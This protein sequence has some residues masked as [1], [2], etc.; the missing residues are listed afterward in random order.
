MVYLKFY[1]DSSISTRI[2]ALEAYN[3]PLWRTDDT[4]DNDLNMEEGIT[5][6]LWHY[7]RTNLTI[8]RLTDN[9]IKTFDNVTFVK[10]SALMIRIIICLWQ[11]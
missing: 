3:P 4:I 7:W 8:R 9:I 2:E 11:F 5:C 6:T 1:S 10:L